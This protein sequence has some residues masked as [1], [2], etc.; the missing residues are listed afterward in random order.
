MSPRPA[1]PLL[2][3]ATRSIIRRGP[4]CTTVILVMVACSATHAD[5]SSDSVPTEPPSPS[6][7]SLSQ[8]WVR[9]AVAGDA[10]AARA[11][12]FDPTLGDSGLDGV[13]DVISDYNQRLGNPTVWVSEDAHPTSSATFA[14]VCFSLSYPDFTFE[15]ALAVREWDEEGLRIWE[16]R[17]MSDCLTTSATTIA[18]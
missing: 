10:V 13:F 9:A 16:Y 18:P 15:G 8:E 11:L 2:S 1:Q 5:P 14:F 17:R 7:V 4:T 12:V 6:A 3:P